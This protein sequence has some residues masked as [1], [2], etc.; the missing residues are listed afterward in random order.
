MKNESTLPRLHPRHEIFIREV[1]AHGDKIAAYRIAYPSAG[2]GAARNGASR[3]MNIKAIEERIAEARNRI[4]EDTE[5]SIAKMTNDKL[6]SLLDIRRHLASILSG[7]TTFTKH[8]REEG[9]VKAIE[10]GA[11][12]SEVLQALALNLKLDREMSKA[13]VFSVHTILRG[14]GRETKE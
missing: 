14:S 8:Y 1:I 12:A 6:D 9:K 10:V 7:E 5:A 2:Y 4:Q 3:V 13:P 11:N